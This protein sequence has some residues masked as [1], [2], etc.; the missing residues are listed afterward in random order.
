MPNENTA[1]GSFD[2]L[3][4]MIDPNP[5]TRVDIHNLILK[6]EEAMYSAGIQNAKTIE[7]L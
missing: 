6:L 5:M 7:S 1:M 3:R 4:S 2:I